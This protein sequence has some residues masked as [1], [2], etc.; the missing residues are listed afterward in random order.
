MFV[1]EFTR[2][3]IS[4]MIDS[5]KEVDGSKKQKAYVTQKE[6]L[7]MTMDSEA[8]FQVIQNS[9]KRK[10]IYQVTTYRLPYMT[11]PKKTLNRIFYSLFGFILVI[12][13]A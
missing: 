10:S 7:M 4:N 11:M 1:D 12:S 6:R 9:K 8:D 3:S 2:Y 13:L 5:A